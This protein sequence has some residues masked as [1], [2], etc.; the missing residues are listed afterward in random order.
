[1]SLEEAVKLNTEAL[2]RLT[3]ALGANPKITSQDAPEKAPPKPAATPAPKAAAPVKTAAPPKAAAAPPA[4]APVTTP[5]V[6][7]NSANSP[8]YAAAS[9]AVLE[10]VKVKGR[11][12]ALV[13]LANVQEG[14]KRLPDV[15][16]EL[17]PEVVKQCDAARVSA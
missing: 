16:L 7:V 5:P 8:E 6:G 12:A 9:K 4:K 10:L 11:D 15:G 2:N 17:L 13:V 14:A 3:A 1:M